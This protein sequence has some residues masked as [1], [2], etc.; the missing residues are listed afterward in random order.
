M[1]QQ[2]LLRAVDSQ[3]RRRG[4][5]RTLLN[6]TEALLRRQG[7]NALGHDFTLEQ[8]EQVS[9]LELGGRDAESQPVGAQPGWVQLEEEPWDGA[10]VRETERVAGA[11][12][13][14]RLVGAIEHLPTGRLVAFT[15]LNLLAHRQDAA[16]QEETLVVAEYRGDRA[17]AK[18]AF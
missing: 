15:V 17:V 8:V 6:A 1:P 3:V 12:G 9:R 18:G 11:Q 10:R 5:G 13:C 2:I 16:Y 14:T 7:R 4:V